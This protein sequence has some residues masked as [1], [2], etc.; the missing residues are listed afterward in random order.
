[1]K[2]LTIQLI[3]NFIFPE[4]DIFTLKRA[5]RT[6]YEY[7][8]TEIYNYYKL[9]GTDFFMVLKPEV[10]TADLVPFLRDFYSEIYGDKYMSTREAILEEFGKYDNI[11][12]EMCE[13]IGYQKEYEFYPC[14]QNDA[15][16]HPYLMCEAGVNAETTGIIIGVIPPEKA[17]FSMLES[18]EGELQEK[19]K[20]HPLVK[21]IK[22]C[23]G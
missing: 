13:D 22:V 12:W 19:L 20:E 5:I 7:A 11:T 9:G 2:T 1:M 18:L 23:L 15:Y 21:A 6:L 16:P 17:T 8:P 4:K 14:F 10:V 3:K